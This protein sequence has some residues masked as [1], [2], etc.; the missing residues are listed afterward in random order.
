[1]ISSDT[2]VDLQKISSKHKL[3]SLKCSPEGTGLLL[4]G[5]CVRVALG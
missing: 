4:S 2:P 1:M 3:V 5:G